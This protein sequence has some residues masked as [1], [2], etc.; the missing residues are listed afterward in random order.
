MRMTTVL[1]VG[2][3]MGALALLLRSALGRKAGTP[4]GTGMPLSSSREL[5]LSVLAPWLPFAA[6]VWG[7]VIVCECV[8]VWCCWSCRGGLGGSCLPAAGRRGM[9]RVRGS[10]YPSLSLS[11]SLVRSCSLSL[12][13]HTFK[14]THSYSQ[15]HTQH[16]HTHTPMALAHTTRTHRLQH[17]SL[18][19]ERK[20][21]RE[22]EEGSKGGMGKV[23]GVIGDYRG[24]EG[25]NTKISTQGNLK[26]TLKLIMQ[27]N[28]EEITFTE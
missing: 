7:C 14:H 3:S 13:Q 9:L 16:K 4:W 28:F 2:S 17:A 19:W 22:R 18:A 26:L 6:C 23:E 10:V 5:L 25:K 1:P 8:C 11:L 20:K 15:T 12:S 21:G 27:G 24:L